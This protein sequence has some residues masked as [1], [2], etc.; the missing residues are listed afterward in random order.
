MVRILCFVA[1][2]EW[3]CEVCRRRERVGGVKRN[4]ALIDRKKY[5]ARIEPVRSLYRARVE[6]V[7]SPSE[8]VT[9]VFGVSRGADEQSRDSIIVD[10]IQSIMQCY[11]YCA[12]V[13]ILSKWHK[14]NITEVTK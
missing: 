2:V 8:K 13:N 3:L 7:L 14:V 9:A 4:G 6:A 10:I 12:K 11:K 5:G 1:F